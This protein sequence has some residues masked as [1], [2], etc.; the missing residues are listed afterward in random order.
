MVIGIEVFSAD[1]LLVWYDTMGT[2]HADGHLN[3]LYIDNILEILQ[4]NIMRG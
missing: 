2:N 4:E 3:L 1:I